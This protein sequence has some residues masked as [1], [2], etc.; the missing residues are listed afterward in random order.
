MLSIAVDGDLNETAT[1]S[2]LASLEILKV[3][4]TLWSASAP[5]PMGTDAVLTS[6][7]RAADIDAVIEGNGHRPRL[8]A[9]AADTSPMEIRRLLLAGVVSVIPENGFTPLA[10]AFAVVAAASGAVAGIPQ[11]E[12]HSIAARLE[13]PPRGLAADEAYFL[14]LVATRTIEAAGE[15]AG[16]SRRQAQRYFTRLRSDLGLRDH[17]AASVKAARWGLVDVQGQP[18]T[19]PGGE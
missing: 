11:H 16:L 6:A 14:G 12:A 15:I 9:L 7:S 10:Q 2:M 3:G 8:I 17:A 13:E 18:T 19:R 4:A 5:I 1:S